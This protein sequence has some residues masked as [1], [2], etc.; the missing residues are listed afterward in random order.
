[1]KS[2]IAL[3]ILTELALVQGTG[4]RVQSHP[5][6]NCKR[7]GQPV[8]CPGFHWATCSH[9]YKAVSPCCSS[10]LDQSDMGPTHECEEQSP[11]CIGYKAGT[12]WGYCTGKNPKYGQKAL[13]KEEIAKYK[14]LALLEEI[15]AKKKLKEKKIKAKMYEERTSG[16]CTDGGADWGYITTMAACKEGAEIFGWSYNSVYFEK[17]SD[18]P[19]GCWVSGHLYFNTKTSST[20]S[21]T[22]NE[23]CLC[24]RQS[25]KEKAAKEK[26]AKDKAA[27]EK[28]AKEKAAKEKAAKEKAAKE[29]AAKENAAKEKAA[30]E[31]K[32]KGT[33]KKEQ[34]IKD[35]AKK[36]LNTLSYHVKRIIVPVKALQK[37][38]K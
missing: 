38:L 24:K 37:I 6:G 22:S 7:S 20:A 26:A 21:C 29:K 8:P 15:K 17:R 19:R 32:S 27:K 23:K 2:V 28:A 13:S 10:K 12:K 35:Q 11:V 36:L 33:P 31:K 18:F 30:K 4:L 25:K 5:R 14:K 9:H 34:A 3:L 16:K 1:M